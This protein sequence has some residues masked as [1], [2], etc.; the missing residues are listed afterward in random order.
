MIAVNINPTRQTRPQECVLADDD[1]YR[2]ALWLR[3]ALCELALSVRVSAPELAARLLDA[4][5]AIAEVMRSAPV[6]PG[7]G[8]GQSP[9]AREDER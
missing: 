4:E 9:R 6:T 7:E 2:K 8:D 3:V 5:G 1:P